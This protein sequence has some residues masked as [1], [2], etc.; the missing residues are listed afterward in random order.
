MGRHFPCRSDGS[1]SCADLFH[2]CKIPKLKSTANCVLSIE[3]RIV[4]KY[5]EIVRLN[6]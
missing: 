3:F 4:I 2:S 6:L 1:L 5:V